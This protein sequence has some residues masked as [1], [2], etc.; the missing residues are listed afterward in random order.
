MPRTSLPADV[1]NVIGDF[2]GHFNEVYSHGEVT[3][4]QTYALRFPLTKRGYVG[5]TRVKQTILVE[6]NDG[7]VLKNRVVHGRL[8]G[9]FKWQEVRSR[10]IKDA[11]ASVEG[12]LRILKRFYPREVWA[13]LET[14]VA[15]LRR[16]QTIRNTH[17]LVS[18]GEAQW[19]FG[20]VIYV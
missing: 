8:G 18:S 11:I 1:L 10:R 13:V 16:R 12:T 4:T 3:K 6:K 20:G 7:S 5:H 19:G 17:K 15:D 9:R 14:A 2:A